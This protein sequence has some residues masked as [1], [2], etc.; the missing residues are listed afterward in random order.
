[1]LRFND[2][3][4]FYEYMRGTKNALGDAFVYFPATEGFAKLDLQDKKDDEKIGDRMV[5]ILGI[6]NALAFVMCEKLIWSTEEE[7]FFDTLED[8]LKKSEKAK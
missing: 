6:N 7:K 8:T 2:K 4:V 5:A 1:M 3:L